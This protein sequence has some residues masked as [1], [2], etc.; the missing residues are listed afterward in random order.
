MKI[1]LRWIQFASR[2]GATLQFML[3]TCRVGGGRMVT[4]VSSRQYTEL[5]TLSSYRVAMRNLSYL[6]QYQLAAAWG[7]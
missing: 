5:Q 2:F 3:L 4:A 7:P 6:V 1:E